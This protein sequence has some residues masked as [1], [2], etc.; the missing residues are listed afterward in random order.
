MGT[1]SGYPQRVPP[2]PTELSPEQK[3]L[4]AALKRAHAAIGEADERYRAKLAECDAAGIPIRQ[5]AQELHIERKTIYRHLGR[6]MK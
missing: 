4:L 2:R 1:D 3:R 5:L 6:P